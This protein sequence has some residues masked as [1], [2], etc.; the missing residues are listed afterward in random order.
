[1]GCSSRVGFAQ[2]IPSGI[3]RIRNMYSIM[4]FLMGELLLNFLK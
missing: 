4:G 3:A 2:R 1:M